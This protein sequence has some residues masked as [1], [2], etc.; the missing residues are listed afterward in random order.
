MPQIYNLREVC[1]LLKVSKVQALRLI[2]G[3]KIRAFKCGNG[4]RVS[5]EAIKKFM[6]ENSNMKEAK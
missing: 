2:H 6:E 1:D 5:E 3:C 4:W